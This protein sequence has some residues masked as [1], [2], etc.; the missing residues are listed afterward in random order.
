MAQHLGDEVVRC[1]AMDTT[2][3]LVRGMKATYYGEQITIPVGR[4][5]LGRILNVIGKPVDEMGPVDNKDEVPDPSPGP[6]F[7]EQS[8]SHGAL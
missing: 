6:L 8:T 3:G 1:V 2:D 4:E 7:S 5:T